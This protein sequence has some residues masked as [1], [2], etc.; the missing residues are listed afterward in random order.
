MSVNLLTCTAI[1]LAVVF[2]ER[3]F[4]SNLRRYE[5]AKM[6]EKLPLLARGNGQNRL[7][8]RSF[9]TIGCGVR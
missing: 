1:G 5:C 8:K 6:M 2:D 7:M 4:E 9:V 3:P